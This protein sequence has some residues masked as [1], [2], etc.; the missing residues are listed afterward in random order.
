[1]PI[2]SAADRL[3]MVTQFGAVCNLVRGSGVGAQNWDVSGIFDRDF[4][5][6]R[7]VESYRPV[8]TVRKEDIYEPGQLQN[9]TYRATSVNVATEYGG[10]GYDIVGYQHDGTGMVVLI[11]EKQA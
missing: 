7:G 1:V 10:N 8:L 6:V 11:L 5:E 2:E 4:V 3:A 9:D